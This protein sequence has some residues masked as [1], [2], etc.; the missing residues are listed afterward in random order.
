MKITGFNSVGY[1]NLLINAI[2]A[3]KSVGIVTNTY[4]THASPSAAYAKEGV[5]CLYRLR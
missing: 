3:G 4:V 1:N 5:Y 2:K